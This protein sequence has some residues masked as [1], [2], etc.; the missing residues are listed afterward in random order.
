MSRTILILGDYRQSI[1]VVRSL[2][3]AG[4]R[5]VTGSSGG[6]FIDHSRYTAEAWR[7]PPLDDEDA[8]AP[9]R[10]GD[11][12]DLASGA[13]AR[14]GADAR[15][16][17][18]LGDFL[19]T[20]GD[21]DLV[22]P[23]GEDSLRCLARDAGALG[24]AIAVMPAPGAV[25]ACLDKVQSY[26][27]AEAAGVPLAPYRTARD[28]A[29]VAAAAAQVG[30]PC[31][32]KPNDSL[33]PFF[34]HKAIVCRERADIDRHLPA[35]PAGN[36]FLIVQRYAPGHRHNCHFAAVDGHIHTYFEQR[37]LRTN[38]RD[39]TGYGVDGISVRPSARLRAHSEALVRALAY[40]GVGCVQFLVDGDG[41]AHFLEMNPRLD[42]TCALPYYCGY[43]FPH[44][45]VA[46]ARR[47]HGQA[48]PLPAMPA[49]YPA[50]R[51][52]GWLL[53]DLQGLVR[54]LGRGEL[55]WDETLRW[56]ARSGGTWLQA[57]CHVIWSARDPVPG[58]YA[59]GRWLGGVALRRARALVRRARG[60]AVVRGAAGNR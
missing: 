24:R 14:P 46:I 12:A 2:A 27:H 16:Y 39:A 13:D 36:P 59:Y 51:R 17:R 22:F 10:A 37:V 11:A 41:Q 42:A 49:N 30:Y 47:R 52:I 4:Y 21:I 54:A 32:I 20:R 44:L 45:A 19:R 53:G 38:R 6:S 5:I 26:A 33:R 34:A 25:T 9:D 58:A 48:V 15:F 8:G 50:G 43:D 60:A 28:L 7:H 18:A 40:T 57:D 55:P 1:T 31:V 3:R 23:V 35:W 29:E 56:L